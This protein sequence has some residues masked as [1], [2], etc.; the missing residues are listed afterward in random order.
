MSERSSGFLFFL[1][2]TP[3]PGSTMKTSRQEPMVTKGTSAGGASTK[4]TTTVH[5][6]APSTSHDATS[7]AVVKGATGKAAGTHMPHSHMRKP[8]AAH[9]TKW[10]KLDTD[11]YQKG[12]P[13]S[14]I[15]LS[16]MI[17]YEV[18]NIF[19]V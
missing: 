19:N 18:S 6:T 2:L 10:S 14:V 3:G 4:K 5:T 16:N 13:V 12:Y 17:K 15:D 7:G 8:R 9:R 11:E 1:Y